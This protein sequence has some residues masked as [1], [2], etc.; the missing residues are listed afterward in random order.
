LRRSQ[1]HLKHARG[2]L[3]GFDAFGKQDGANRSLAGGLENR[4]ASGRERRSDL[5]ALNNTKGKFHGAM[6]PT[7]PIGVLITMFRLPLT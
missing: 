3:G 2:Q 5:F 7:T 1:H 4:W 6:A